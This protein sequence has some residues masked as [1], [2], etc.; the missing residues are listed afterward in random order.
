MPKN[1]FLLI[2]I[3][4][5]LFLGFIA[6]SNST[7]NPSL[8]SQSVLG[9]ENEQ[10]KKAEEQAKEAGKKEEEIKKEGNKKETEVKTADGQRIK[11]KVEDDGTTKIEIEYG[12]LK[13]KYVWEDNELKLKTLKSVL[14]LAKVKEEEFVEYQ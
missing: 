6:S 13:A 11:T 12:K 5:V 3:S 14:V 4:S 8:N 7:I 1:Y 10:E 9:E 2:L